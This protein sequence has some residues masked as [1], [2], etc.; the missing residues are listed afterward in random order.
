MSTR[1]EV[2]SALDGYADQR[3]ADGA[4]SRQGEVDDLD[5]ANGNLRDALVAAQARLAQT[6]QSLA[7]LRAEYEAH[8]AT[9]QPP[10]PPTPVRTTIIGMSSPKPDWDTRLGQVGKDGITARRIFADL[11]A[12]AGH[13]MDLVQYAHDNGMMPVFSFKV[14]SVTTALTGAYDAWVKR[15]GER[16]AAHG[17]RTTVTFHHEPADNMTGPQFVALN[18]RWSPMLRSETVLFGPFINGWLLDRQV[19]TFKT[20]TSPD[21]LQDGWDWFGIDTYE[22]G[23]IDA[24]GPIKPADRIPKL[25]EFVTSEGVPDKPLGVGEF[26]GYSGETISAAGEAILS[27][28]QVWFGCMWNA[29]TGK[30]YVLEGDRLAAF[31][32]T[33]AD[34]RVKR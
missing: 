2:V 10:P 17:K 12:D 25:V 30:G 7:V 32:A 16:L 29:T 4:A 1:D 18:R 24:P 26:N 3:Y 19:S 34:A 8:M 6:E 21:L 31:K 13:Q 5:V 20:Y 28:P 27:T 9:H 22:S 15:L 23:T 11:Q 14:P 33:K